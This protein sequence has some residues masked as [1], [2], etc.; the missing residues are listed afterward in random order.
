MCWYVV[1]SNDRHPSF[2]AQT[3]LDEKE[4]YTLDL[5]L[6]AVAVVA[7]IGVA[8][9]ISQ[10]FH[11]KRRDAFK[12]ETALRG[13]AY[14]DDDTDNFL[15][16][17]HLTDIGRSRRVQ[18]H[19]EGN[20]DGKDFLFCD[21]QYTTGSGK[22]RRVS[23][24]SV[25]VYDHDL[26]IPNFTLDPENMFHKI[27]SAFGYQDIDFASH[28]KFSGAYLLRGPDEFAI[29][30]FFSYDVLD[31]FERNQGLYVEVTDTHILFYQSGTRIS[32]PD[33]ADFLTRGS[34]VYRLLENRG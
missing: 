4:R 25:L 32:P 28:P 3:K 21:Y 15:P 29:R 2:P 1:L 20:F 30:E 5:L 27:G 13:F 18:H 10:Y 8:I 31:F 23:N 11:N 34:E 26:S 17:F 33:L 7:F 9:A 16:H 6:I 19:I 14:I 24:Q 22:S 12:Q